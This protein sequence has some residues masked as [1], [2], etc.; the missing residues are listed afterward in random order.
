MN[1][2]IQGYICVS[3]PT[4]ENK[5]TVVVFDTVMFLIDGSASIDYP[6]VDQRRGDYIPQFYK[7]LFSILN[8]SQ[9]QSFA[10]QAKTWLPRKS[11][12]MMWQYSS[13]VFKAEIEANWDDAQFDVMAE[14]A[15]GQYLTQNTRTYDYLKQLLERYEFKTGMSDPRSMLIIITDGKPTTDVCYFDSMC[16][17]N[18][19]N[20]VIFL[21]N[22]RFFS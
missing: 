20:K 15:I 11:R 2:Y 21:I 10:R 4:C 17:T 14:Q 19:E 7:V 22:R 13:G 9:V 8:F 1:N 6:F 16:K 18:L 3:Q 12:I 5:E